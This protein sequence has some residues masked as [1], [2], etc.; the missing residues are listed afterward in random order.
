MPFLNTA[1]RSNKNQVGKVVGEAKKKKREEQ[2]E[3][4]RK[5]E[6]QKKKEKQDKDS[7][8]KKF[9]EKEP[10]VNNK[11]KLEEIERVNMEESA[12]E[13][14]EVEKHDDDIGIEI[15]IEDEEEMTN[16]KK[17]EHSDDEKRI[18]METSKGCLG[19]L[20]HHEDFDP[21]EDQN[22]I[23]LYKGLDVYIEPLSERKPVTKEEFYEK[24]IEKFTKITEERSELIET[25]RAGMTKFGED[26]GISDF[27]DQ[28][29]NLFKDAEFNYYDSSM[30]EYSESE[31]DADNN[32]KKND[33]E[34]EKEKRNDISK[35][36]EEAGREQKEDEE[37]E[38]DDLN[39]EHEFEKLTGDDREVA[40]SIEVDETENEKEKQIENV[41]E[42]QAEEENEKQAENEEKQDDIG[43][44][45]EEAGSETKNDG[46][47]VHAKVD[48]PNE[49]MKDK[50]ADK[51]KVNDGNENEKDKQDEFM[52][53]EYDLT[54]SECEELE[55]QATQDIKK[56]K[57]T[58]RK[59]PEDMTPHTFSLGLTPKEFEPTEK[60]KEKQVEKEQKKTSIKGKATT[61]EVMVTQYLFSMKGE[62]LDFVFKTK[63]GAATI[64]DY[65]QTLALQL[66][67]EYNVIDTFSLILNREHKMNSKGKR[68]KYFFH[69][70][71]ITKE[72]FKWKKAN[73][74]YDEKKQFEGF[75]KTI[76]SEF[77]KY[78][79]M[80]NMKDLE[81]AFFP[82]IAHEHYYLVVFNFLKGNT[83]IID[84]SR[85]QMTYETKYKTVCE[86]LPTI[87]RPK[88]GTTKNDTD[89]G[90]FLMMHM[91]HYNGE[92]ANNWNLKF[93]TEKQGN[94]LDII[95]M[96]V[97]LATNILSHEINIH[98]EKI[99][100]EA[101]EFARR[102]TNK[103]LRKKMIN[104]A[105]KKKKEKQEFERVQS[106]I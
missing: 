52:N 105:I 96:R 33:D 74:K 58:K 41:K 43:K 55:Y 45:T 98:Q 63:D 2:I 27:Y 56:K 59:S 88:W 78:P 30:D 11:R 29:K 79:E 67:V 70:T 50:E 64:R 49:Q 90:I 23:D 8:Q 103:D 99:S 84:N 95:K 5:L 31:S 4:K 60:E 76:K 62:E 1:T 46:E 36:T 47:E 25:L 24:I 71:M 73:G 57:T 42:Q 65:M 92:T 54:E 39:N 80:K 72:M 19:N 48:D 77:E 37:D 102:N 51:Q 86:L 101:Q 61:D 94:T 53:K 66:K 12:E 10:K 6:E 93:P 87:I 17:L 82:I 9:D 106:A 3:K 68:T 89:C 100:T 75:S 18:T 69:T 20:E 22:G 14:S 32:N 21:D 97:R 81:M 7:N 104:E 13:E 16:N 28:Y 38:Q 40:V 34:E 44:G 91:E 35:G 26:Q 15:E 83:V 85:T